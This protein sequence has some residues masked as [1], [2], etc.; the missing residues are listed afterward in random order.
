MKILLATHNLHKIREFRELLKAHPQFDVLSLV[1]FPDYVAP[2]ETEETFQ[3]NALLK[4]KHAANAL[5]LLAV[6]DDSGLIVPAL[7]NRPGVYSRRYA[8][9]NATDND[10]RKKLLQEMQGLTGDAR[11]AYFEC[12][13]ALVAPTGKEK[14]VT[15][16]CHGTLAESERGSNGFGYDPLFIKYDYDLTFAELPETTKNRISHRRKAFDKLLLALES[17]RT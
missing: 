6:A 4:A 13:L 15:G 2:E 5:N 9:D 11:E 17:Y 12:C 7:G 14:V 3:G 10:N 8:G 16:T 1:Q